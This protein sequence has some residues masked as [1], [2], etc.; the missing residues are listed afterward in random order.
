MSFFYSIKILNT[1]VKTT[2]YT[3]A[4]AVPLPQELLSLYL[5]RTQNQF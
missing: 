5:S 4:P 1:N 2:N 3:E